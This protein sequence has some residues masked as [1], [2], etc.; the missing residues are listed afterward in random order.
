MAHGPELLF[1]AIQVF[2]NETVLTAAQLCEHTE[3]T[4][5]YTFQGKLSGAGILRWL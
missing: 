1:G 4:E 2:S 5:L 3:T